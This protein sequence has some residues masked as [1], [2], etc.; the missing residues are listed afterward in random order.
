MSLWG[1][2]LNELIKKYD[3]F[4]RNKRVAVVSCA[5]HMVDY[6]YGKLIDSY[7][8]VV[9]FNQSGFILNKFKKYLGIKTNIIYS[10]FNANHLYLKNVPSELKKNKEAICP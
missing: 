5:S 9:R 1:L 3:K 6:N 7:D 2:I 4:L 8:V 10:S